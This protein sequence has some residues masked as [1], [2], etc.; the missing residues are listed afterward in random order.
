VRAAGKAAAFCEKAPKGGMLHLHPYGTLGR[1]Q[2]AALL[3]DVDPVLNLAPV[4]QD[5]RKSSG[6]VALY[7]E[8]EAW[9]R[10]LPAGADFLSLPARDRE[11]FASLLFLPPGKQPFER[12]NGVFEFID[13]AAYD[14]R[15]VGAA[16]QIRGGRGFS[17]QRGEVPGAG[18][19]AAA[20]RRGAA[21]GPGRRT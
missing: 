20:L 3:R 9:L 13:F 2:A 11:K 14:H 17:G 15:F 6:N 18:G 5:I 21:A 4:F 1:A 16:F 10:S 19:R 7:P 12:F 8:E